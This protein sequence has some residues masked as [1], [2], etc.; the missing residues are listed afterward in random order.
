MPKSTR[1]I[2]E[3]AVDHGVD[4]PEDFT[5]ALADEARLGERVANLM[6]KVE[7]MLATTQRW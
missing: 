1:S 2:Y 3:A 7:R 4:W 5:E 6:E